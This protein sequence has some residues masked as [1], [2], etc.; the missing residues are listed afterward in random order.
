MLA[1][2]EQSFKINMESN[3]NSKN[4]KTG[5]NSVNKISTEQKVR[6]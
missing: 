4:V 6:P 2:N 1:D 3:K 5:K